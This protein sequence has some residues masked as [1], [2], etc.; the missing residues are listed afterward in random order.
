[1]SKRVL[2]QR[3]FSIPIP[4]L[5]GVAERVVRHAHNISAVLCFTLTS[6]DSDL[7]GFLSEAALG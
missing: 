3:P 5:S 4:F 7:T 1:M 6:L 2:L